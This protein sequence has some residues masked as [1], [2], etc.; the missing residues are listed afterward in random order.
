VPLND[1]PWNPWKFFFKTIQY[2]ALGLPVVA[3]R[4]GSNAEVI[5][6]GVNGY[7]VETEEEWLDRLLLLA[8]DAGLRRR[9][10]EAARTTV[11]ERYSVQSQMPR[12]VSVFENALRSSGTTTQSTRS[13]PGGPRIPRR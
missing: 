5:D 4:M 1:L 2:M 12:L 3:R 8:S 11:V 7:L 9:L 6:D 10:G 13:R